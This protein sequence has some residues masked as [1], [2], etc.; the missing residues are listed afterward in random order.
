MTRMTEALSVTDGPCAPLGER[1]DV[2]RMVIVV[3]ECSTALTDR[4]P[5]QHHLSP[6]LVASIVAA[7]P[8]GPSLTFA[9]ACMT[10]AVG[11]F[12]DEHT[13][14]RRRARVLGFRTHEAANVTRGRNCRR[15]MVLPE[16][17]SMLVNI[18]P[19]AVFTWISKK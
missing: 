8:C 6:A 14:T 4:V 16:I 11:A 15:P 18:L 17:G 10:M 12:V 13:A 1:D 7:L 2:I 3:R 9:F 19:L 5:H